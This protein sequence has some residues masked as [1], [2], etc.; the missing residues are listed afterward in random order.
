MPGKEEFQGIGSI[1][2]SAPPTTAQKSQDAPLLQPFLGF[3]DHAPR[4]QHGITESWNPR[5]PWKDVIH[6]DH[7]SPAPSPDSGIKVLPG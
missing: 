2:C 5:T 7:W 6:G 1:C 3:L 4:F